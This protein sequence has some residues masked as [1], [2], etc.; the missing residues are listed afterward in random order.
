MVYYLC[1]ISSQ[2]SILREK[3]LIELLSESR[4]KYKENNIT[5]LLLY[6]EG[7]FVEFL[8]GDKD[9]VQSIFKKTTS[10]KRHKSVFKITESIT[11]QRKFT[12][13]SMSF[14]SLNK[15]KLSKLFGY[16]PFEIETILSEFSEEDN[17]PGLVLLRSFIKQSKRKQLQYS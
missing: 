5:G 8:E 14:P 2:K 1:Y 12:N 15:S 11:D 9:T 7:H 3:D 10:D 6:F 4:K 13:W 16:K 17:H